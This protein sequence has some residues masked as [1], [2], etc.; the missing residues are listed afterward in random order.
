[1]SSNCYFRKKWSAS[2]LSFL[3]YVQDYVHYRIFI[4]KTHDIT[5]NQILHNKV[6]LPHYRIT[7]YIVSME[8]KYATTIPQPLVNTSLHH[9]NIAEKQ[10]KYP[11]HMYYTS[12]T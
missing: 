1:M 5:E 8:F 2:N 6:A 4:V 12:R 9:S 11:E 7:K 3:P 10:Y